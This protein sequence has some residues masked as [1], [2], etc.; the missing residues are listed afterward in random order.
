MYFKINNTSCLYYV[1]KFIKF[2]HT[3]Y[4]LSIFLTYF[5]IMHL[6]HLYRNY[7]LCES[8][9]IHLW[10]V[11]VPPVQ[12]LLLFTIKYY[13]YI[14]CLIINY[15]NRKRVVIILNI[16]TVHLKVVKQ[17]NIIIMISFI[18]SF[19]LKFY[20]YIDTVRYL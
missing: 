10:I 18:F 12:T 3:L 20:F 7:Y 4:I 11:N 14:I 13:I 19:C 2:Y 8:T 6:I 1:I 17:W 16:K 9:F 5:N 15:C